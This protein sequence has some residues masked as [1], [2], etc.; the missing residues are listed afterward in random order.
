MSRIG[1][2][3]YIVRSMKTVRDC[4]EIPVQMVAG[5]CT[6]WVDDTGTMVNGHMG[7]PPHLCAQKD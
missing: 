5:L 3:L 2:G 1:G 4:G 7:A 6:E